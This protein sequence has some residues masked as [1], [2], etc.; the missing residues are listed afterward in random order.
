L[1]NAAFQRAVAA[2]IRTHAPGPR[3]RSSLSNCAATD[4][5]AATLEEDEDEEGGGEEGESSSLR[6]TCEFEDGP[7]LVEVHP[8]PVKTLV[9]MREKLAEYLPPDSRCV[10]P[11]AANVLDPVRASVVACGPGRVRQVVRWFAAAGVAGSGGGCDGD[12]YPDGRLR[13]CR[14]K[15]GF[16]M[17][18]A[19][20]AN[21]YRDVKLFMLFDAPGGL[22]IIGEV[23]VVRLSL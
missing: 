12:G 9:R 16:A 22:S 10:W 13:V 21:G 11:L 8:G 20:V 19:A 5:P 4:R 7:D 2:V 23:Q 6:V 15:N 14:V 18:R 3:R 1:V 17:V